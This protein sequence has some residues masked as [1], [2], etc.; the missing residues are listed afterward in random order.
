M[1]TE[2]QVP[3]KA[4]LLEALRSSER[5]VLARLR[6][7]P[8]TELEQGRYENGWNARQILAHVA[9]IEWSYPRL[10]D[11]A[12]QAPPAAANATPAEARQAGRQESSSTRTGTVRGGIDDYNQR[13]VEKRADA[14]VEELLAEFQKNRAATIAAVEEVDE[15]LLATPIQSAGGI[16]GALAS[17]IDT[18]A[19]QHILAHVNDIVDAG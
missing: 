2:Q 5:E 11:I 8:E 7:L 10:I 6:S 17:V 3:S 14:S 19:V 18:I 13:Q 15:A 12:K 16:S 9:S 4:A 1:V